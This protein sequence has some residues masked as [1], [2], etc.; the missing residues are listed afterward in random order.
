[1]FF[2]GIGGVVLVLLIY[3]T[4]ADRLVTWEDEIF[5]VS[6]GLSIARS[7]APIESV[8][9][10][11]PHS[12]SPIE[13]YGPVS[14]EAAGQLIRVFGL[15]TGPWRLACFGG[16]F[17]NLLV[18]VG[19]VRLGGG[20]DWAQ[21]ITALTLAISGFAAAMQPGRWDFV[22]SGLFLGGLLVL[23]AG[24]EAG[25]IALVWR[26][27]VAGPLIGLALGSTPRVLTLAL[28]A[29]VT[30]SL[31]GLLFSGMRKH[32]LLG[33][34]GAAALAVLTQNLLLLP[35]HLNSLSW[36][37]YVRSSTRKDPHNATPVTG[38]GGWG[39]NFQNHKILI[40]VAL[41]LFAASLCSV[42]PRVRPVPMGRKL[43]FR[44]FLA[45][46]AMTNLLLM[47]LLT[48]G[49]LGLSGFWLTPVV[50]ALMCWFD[51]DSVSETKWGM[52]A[53]TLVGTALTA[54]VFQ[55]VRPLTAT[56]LTWNR[57]SN[58]IVAAFVRRTTPNNAALYGPIGGYFYPVEMA[59]RTYLYLYEQERGLIPWL[60]ANPHTDPSVSV[61]EELDEQSCTQPIY[62]IWPIDDP[63]RHSPAE[64][65]PKTLQERLGPKIS[66]LR[67][68]PLT[69]WKEGLLHEL[70]GFAGKYGLSDV[71]IFRLRTS[72]ICGKG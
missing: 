51:W 26:V 8:M 38:T 58:G 63:A 50:V 12:D 42:L 72:A 19:L 32:L 70:G 61:N 65:M 45:S 56:A 47:L 35:W 39:L 46:F 71:A 13:F 7:Q 18:A 69:K 44:L 31:V 27:A 60:P 48:R 14:F 29:A 20:D 54:L 34:L 11:Y 10:L 23:L 5:V 30:V 33:A 21:L 25:G 28:A 22:S 40:L 67:Q 41:C 49:S 16:I 1:L 4:I 52:L 64:P 24:I 62:V 66:E 57:R 6:A 15:K 37:A 55:A 68:P 59:G 9:A 36:Y 43:A 17:L 53:A 3:V 2:S